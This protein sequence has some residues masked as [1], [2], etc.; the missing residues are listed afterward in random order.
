[1]LAPSNAAG[2]GRMVLAEACSASS[3]RATRSAAA[4]FRSATALLYSTLPASMIPWS[5]IFGRCTS[6]PFLRVGRARQLWVAKWCGPQQLA[7]RAIS[8]GHTSSR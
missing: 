5:C 3:V 2:R 1:M 7:Q 8:A 6:C 4:A